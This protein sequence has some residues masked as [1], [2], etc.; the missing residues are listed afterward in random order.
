M[1]QP[2]PSLPPGLPD[3][4]EVL[5]RLLLHPEQE[6][7][8]ELQDSKTWIRQVA[9]A[10]PPALARRAKSDDELQKVLTPILEESLMLLVRRN[11]K[12]LVEVLFP[13]MLPAIRRAVASMFAS[14]VEGFNQT[15]DQAFSPRGLRWR[16]E[17]I[18][19][20]K[21]FAEVVLS[22]TLIYRVE[23][24]LLIHRKTSLLLSHL[25]ASG[26]T[27]QD[28]AMVSG[29]LTAIGDFARDSF[30]PNADLNTVNMG[31]RVLV[32]EQNPKAV[33][34]VVVRGNPPTELKERLQDVLS[35]I[36]TRFS[37]EI[38]D[39][40]G[41]DRGLEGMR[42]P[43]EGLLESRYQ[44]A[45]AKRPPY[46]LMGIGVVSLLGLGWWSWNSYQTN[47]DW[48]LYLDR[49][50]STPG[51]VLT[52]APRK[53]ELEGL[54]DPLAAEPASL[55][56][57][58]HLR[59][60]RIHS[61][62]QPY[63]SLEPEIILKRIRVRLNAPA[64]V[65]LSLQDGLLRVS[66]SAPEAWAER[67]YELA[68]AFG[69]ERLDLAGLNQ[70]GQRWQDLKQGIEATRIGFEGGQA[71]VLPRDESQIITLAAQLGELNRLARLL[72]RKI[73]I[74][75]VGY[76]DGQGTQQVRTKLAQSRAD[77]VAGRLPRDLGVQTGYTLALL[78]PERTADDLSFNRVVRVELKETPP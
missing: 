26:V 68:P 54:R 6:A 59:S 64:T 77:A 5:R 56:Q 75:L 4:F 61:R 1:T 35:E 67:L 63:Q 15:L 71:Q 74:R 13:V 53:F 18:T 25:V 11:P 76:A 3:E 7:L 52:E 70:M 60:E 47:R 8:G 50:R 73:Q 36:H 24:V 31:E 41:D 65:Q 29:M 72:G 21:T 14:L 22:H 69:I 49:L 58:L 66:G 38:E 62:W 55:L 33:L 37:Q 44:Q 40:Q 34:A 12:L 32:V 45:S 16:F 2:Q 46:A 30:D 57:G 17:A 20:G 28:G 9:E 19:T 42:P 78:R 43:L 39:Y 23:Q 27:V 48:K 51:I 10:L